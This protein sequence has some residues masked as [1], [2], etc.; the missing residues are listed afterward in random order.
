MTGGV[1]CKP[2]LNVV[3]GGA[4]PKEEP[5]LMS[6]RSALGGEAISIDRALKVQEGN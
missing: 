2:F 3:A 5:F 1:G 4:G 6:L